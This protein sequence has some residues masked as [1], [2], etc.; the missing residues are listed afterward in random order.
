[1]FSYSQ[2]NTA[3]LIL[4]S[5]KNYNFFLHFSMVN[6]LPFLPYQAQLSLIQTKLSACSSTICGQNLEL[7]SLPASFQAV[8]KLFFFLRNRFF[9]GVPQRRI[10]FLVRLIASCFRI[11]PQVCKGHQGPGALLIKYDL[12]SV[13]FGNYLFNETQWRI[14]YNTKN[15]LI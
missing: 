7:C 12:F 2:L 10:Q 9:K 6:N 15:I 11:L 3:K 4:V 1:M 13:L 8:S 14:L 5:N